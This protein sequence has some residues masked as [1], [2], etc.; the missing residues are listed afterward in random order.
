MSNS[1]ATIEGTV[2]TDLTISQIRQRFSKALEECIFYPGMGEEEGEVV[3]LE[4]I[5][6]DLC[7]ILVVPSYD[8]EFVELMFDCTT[9]NLFQT[10]AEYENVWRMKKPTEKISAATD[11][12]GQ[13]LVPAYLSIAEL[14]RKYGKEYGSNMI[15]DVQYNISNPLH[16]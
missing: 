4:V 1:V 10:L 2:D 3:H 9:P 16:E 8:H 12:K 7:G 14:N 15:A 5:G 6:D 11:S 13:T